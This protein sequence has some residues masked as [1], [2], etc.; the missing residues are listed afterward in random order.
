MCSGPVVIIMTPLGVV[1]CQNYTVNMNAYSSSNM[2]C[3]SLLGYV[4][5]IIQYLDNY[6]VRSSDVAVFT[7][8]YL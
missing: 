7:V 4:V 3:C 5:C 1:N 6:L 8:V 2:S